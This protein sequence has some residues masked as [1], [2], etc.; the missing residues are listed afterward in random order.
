MRG[1]KKWGPEC[2]CRQG[3][4]ITCVGFASFEQLALMLGTVTV[5]GWYLG[6][7]PGK[8]VDSHH[9]KGPWI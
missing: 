4:P 2:H 9:L 3:S 1:E 7:V 8:F 6:M 5:L